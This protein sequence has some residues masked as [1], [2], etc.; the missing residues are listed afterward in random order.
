MARWL[1]IVLMFALPTQFIWAAAAVY[2]EHEET[3]TSFHV[4]HHSHTHA[5][6]QSQAT[7]SSLDL[8]AGGTAFASDHADCSYCH[9][10]AAQP[11]FTNDLLAV[12]AIGN[13]YIA[14]PLWFYSGGVQSDIYRPKWAAAR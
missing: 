8:L 12:P 11:E 1:L 3:P 4:G 14:P 9:V 10:I 7:D 5:N 2:C 13:T 6:P